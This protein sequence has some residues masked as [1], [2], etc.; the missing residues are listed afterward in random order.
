MRPTPAL[1]PAD[2][3]KRDA[4]RL[5]AAIVLGCALALYALLVFPIRHSI[6]DDTYIHLVYAKH[7]RDGLG[8]VF[9]PGQPVYGT[10]SPL[11]SLG[12]GVLGKTGVDLLALAR[13]LSILFGA[14]SVVAAAR[15]FRRFLDSWV[16]EEG[17][18][19]GRAEL[20][21][22]IAT[23]AFA[24]DAWLVRWSATGMETA[25]ATF[26]VTMG[27]AG[28]VGRRPWGNRVFVPAAWWSV[29]AL[30]RPEAALLIVLLLLRILLS[31]SLADVKR[32]RALWVLLPV[33][34]V[35]GPW[36][37]YAL[38]LYHGVVP[39]T[40]AAKTA[41][42]VSLGQFVDVIVRELKAIA[43]SRGLELVAVIALAPALLSRFWVRRADHFVPIAWM[44][45]LPLLYAAR[46]VPAIS[47]YLVPI[48]PLVVA[49]AWGAFAWLAASE[50]NRPRLARAGLV[51]AGVVSIALSLF[52]WARF[53]VPQARAFESGVEVTLAGMGRWC[54]EH[55]PPGTEIAIPD[56]GA[57][58]YH[59]DRPVVDLAGL[60]TP[61]IT[62][63]LQRY[64][65]DD[66][67]T[68]LRFEGVARPPYLVDRADIPRR[69]L[70]QSPYATCLMP[71]LVGR[72]DQRGIA[73]PEPAYY[74]LYK[75]D[76]IAFDRMQ[77]SIRQASQPPPFGRPW[78]SGSSSVEPEFVGCRVDLS[79][80]K[81]GW[82]GI[83]WGETAGNGNVLDTAA[84]T[85]TRDL[86]CEPDK[87][88]TMRWTRAQI[89]TM[90]KVA[91]ELKLLDLPNPYPPRVEARPGEVRV[92]APY[93]R[94]RLR[95]ELDG[96][97]R[98]F[99]WSNN[100]GEYAI[101]R[102]SEAWLRLRAFTQQLDSMVAA[103]PVI[104]ELP[105]SHCLYR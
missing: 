86:V 45:G 48:L 94:Y 87:T 23:I 75:I 30:V 10:T 42:G 54:R 74:T 17:Y 18:G 98:E 25:L 5:R 78:A 13:A 100:D 99:E 28:Y 57:F 4:R 27:F 52:T 73:H 62:P 60:V 97:C 38:W 11:W 3:R 35:H 64:P 22:A 96:K 68:N 2:R 102:D 19:A 24:G 88:V 9:N 67:V 44:L 95:I 82:I 85:F 77:G 36:L 92:T 16:S 1:T 55:T 84:R 61:A 46:G 101:D 51:A 58:A 32:V 39:A 72:V 37:L 29:A 40:L 41:G 33:A 34:L 83:W 56:I 79:N 26:L 81:S 93:F 53:V 47:R 8:L 65:Y 49:Y 80:G 50:R 69:M 7:F 66:L 15:F 21:W 31:T 43:A 71:I 70:F 20:A 6:T 91:L 59:A 89:D 104:R 105:V 12:L 63:L 90:R 103:H 76:W 14:L